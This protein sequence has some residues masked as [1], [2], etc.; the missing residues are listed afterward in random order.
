TLS[1]SG[2]DGASA[3]DVPWSWKTE[4]RWISAWTS[5]PG[6]AMARLS[7]KLTPGGLADLGSVSLAP[8]GVVSGFVQDSAGH[9]LSGAQVVVVPSKDGEEDLTLSTDTQPA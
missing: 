2:A 5:A 7:A 8:G 4:Q 1:T 3:F 9:A 6:R